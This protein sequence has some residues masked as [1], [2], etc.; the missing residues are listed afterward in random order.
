M[1][2][3]NR[4][5]ITRAAQSVIESLESRRLLAAELASNGTI[6]MTGAM[7]N[8]ETGAVEFFI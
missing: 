5:V 4:I 2:H 6:K 7:Y 3:R 8:L 1:S